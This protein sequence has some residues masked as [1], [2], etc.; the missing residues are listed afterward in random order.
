MPERR[1]YRLFDA[2]RRA[3]TA[4]AGGAPDPQEMQRGISPQMQSN[5]NRRDAQVRFQGFRRTQGR[6]GITGPFGFVAGRTAPISPQA[7]AGWVSGKLGTGFAPELNRLTAPDPME[8]ARGAR[9]PEFIGQ[10]LGLGAAGVRTAE[11]EA[12]TLEA[13]LPFIAPGMQLEQDVTRQGLTEAEAEEAQQA[14]LRPSEVELAQQGVTRG[15]LDIEGLQRTEAGAPTP[16][17]MIADRATGRESLQRRERIEVDQLE[18][19]QKIQ[20]LENDIQSL[21]AQGMMDEANR[22]R[23]QKNAILDGRMGPPAPGTGGPPPMSTG[24]VNPVMLQRHGDEAAAIAQATE[25]EGAIGLLNDIA[26]DKGAPNAGTA[27]KMESALAA[28]EQSLG[29]APNEQ[30]RNILKAE[31]RN[32]AGYISVKQRA[33]LGDMAL[34]GLAGAPFLPLHLLRAATGSVRPDKLRATQQMAKR[35]VE[36]VE[37]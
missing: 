27:E 5:L 13:R 26:G 1:G 20:S 30:T 32:S 17:E 23:Q 36:L 15:D 34:R 3:G 22:L 28:I 29:M 18:R 7:A 10:E 12:G 24:N 21:E 35:I 4:F 31:I 33:G 37:G 8:F 16:E 11:A 9:A 19:E 6:P 25:L 14:L 2:L